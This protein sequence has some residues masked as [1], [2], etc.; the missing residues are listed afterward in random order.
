MF[1]EAEAILA[2]QLV[3]FPLYQR[4]STG[5]VWED[6]IGGYKHNPTQATDTWNIE[7]WYR[8]DLG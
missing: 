1:A 2:Q 3:I 6:E 7:D 4:L 5:A 8:T